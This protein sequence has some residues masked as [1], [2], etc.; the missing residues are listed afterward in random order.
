MANAGKIKATN[1]SVEKGG[2]TFGLAANPHV[3]NRNRRLIISIFKRIKGFPI[4]GERR[5]AP[6][7]VISIELP[8][9]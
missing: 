3:S 1:P 4:A 8:L 7:T 6:E 2:L 5:V 9:K